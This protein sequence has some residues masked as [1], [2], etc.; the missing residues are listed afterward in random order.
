MA[1]CSYMQLARLRAAFAREPWL[2]P[3]I[4]FGL[5]IARPHVPGLPAALSALMHRHPVMCA[6]FP[7]PGSVEYGEP[8]G[9]SEVHVRH[10]DEAWTHERVQAAA[11]VP[12][13]P[14][15]ERL[16]RFAL[17][18][19]P[20]SIDGAVLLVAVDHLIF[21]GYSVEVFRRDLGALL[22]GADDLDAAFGP[23]AGYGGFVAEQQRFVDSSEGQAAREHWLRRWERSGLYPALP[24]PEP[25]RGAHDALRHTA[26]AVKPRDH[27]VARTLPGCGALATLA[28]AM[29]ACSGRPAGDA[30]RVTAITPY[31]NRSR[32]YINSLGYFDNRVQVSFLA[33]ECFEQTLRSATSEW[34]NILRH[35]PYPFELIVREFFTDQYALRATRP[36]LFFTSSPR[37]RAHATGT[38]ELELADFTDLAS[39]K[40]YNSLTVS[41]ERGNA[42]EDRFELIHNA[43]SVSDG[44]VRRL[45][46][47]MAA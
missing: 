35:G 38:T 13:A 15:D 21:D 7:G 33:E 11:R 17:A 27:Q 30:L 31:M 25:P 9:P 36:Y 10:V 39:F 40:D 28:H 8:P 18:A 26:F 1:Q 12:F 43:A 16:Y 47:R 24:Q 32:R 2:K 29:H 6:R 37:P 46:Q 14:G 44:Y 3:P 42:A 45:T 4:A 23:A 22:A 41:H 20:D 19:D 34:M 5:R